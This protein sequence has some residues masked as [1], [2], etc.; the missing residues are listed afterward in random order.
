MNELCH[1]VLPFSSFLAGG[2]QG[3]DV[4][5]RWQDSDFELGYSSKDAIVLLLQGWQPIA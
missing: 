1:W 3:A 2:C 5:L 4:A